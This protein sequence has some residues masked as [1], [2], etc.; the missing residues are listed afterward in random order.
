MNQSQNPNLYPN[1]N[2][3]EFNLKIED[4]ETSNY[5]MKIYS[6]SGQLILAKESLGTNNQINLSS[7]EKGV[8][9]IHIENGNE[10]VVTK[11]IIN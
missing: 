4:S 1:P 3:G 5:S 7:V 11:I 6:L 9:F 2:N 8:Y 10:S